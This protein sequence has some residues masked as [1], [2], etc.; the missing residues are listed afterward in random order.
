MSITI[1]SQY[2]F[3]DKDLARLKAYGIE[4]HFAER[5]Q[6]GLVQLS[7]EVR[8]RA[9]I[10]IGSAS[11]QDERFFGLCPAI[12]WIH[13]PA[14][15]INNEAH[16]IDWE[17]MKRH[18]VTVTASRIHAAVISEL[19]VTYMLMLAK[20]MPS[21]V[22]KQKEKNYKGHPVTLIN[23]TTA[24]VL[25]M[26]TIGRE[27]ARKLKVAFNMRVLGIN[28]DGRQVDHCDRCY[29][30]AA[31]PDI[32]GT[33]DFLIITM[34]LTEKTKHV[35]DKNILQ[36]MKRTAFLIN[37]G[38]GA[39][40]NEPDLIEALRSQQIAGA[41]LDVFEREPL[42][43]DS[44]LWEMDNVVLTPHIAGVFSGYSAGVMNAF[45]ENLE[46]FVR[47]DVLHMPSRANE[48]GY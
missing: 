38:R 20:N 33:C 21:F 9:I 7:E 8:Q 26:G 45:L 42:P 16:W 46:F 44:P 43:L 30:L 23:Q 48:K 18:G 10:Y 12:H 14:A 28:T 5:G 15:G 17:L 22:K 3:N 41:G 31:L 24:L 32:I 1:I 47:G 35:I 37:I 4:Y 11:G 2:R 39:L 34:P 13:H 6:E 19:I 36:K 40:I 29:P 27:T 25:G